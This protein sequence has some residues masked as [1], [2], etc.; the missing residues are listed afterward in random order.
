VSALGTFDKNSFSFK[1]LYSPTVMSQY[2][3]S[4]LCHRLSAILF[5]GTDEQD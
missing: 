2:G 1:I 3:K 5:G 4:G